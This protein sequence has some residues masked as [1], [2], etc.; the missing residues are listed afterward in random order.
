MQTRDVIV[1]AMKSRIKKA[2]HEYEVE[3]PMPGKD[4]VQHA[5]DLDR[6]NGNTLWRDSLAKEMGNLMIAF[7]ILEPGQKAPPGWFK[8]TG[9]PS[10]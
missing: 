7:K 4:V 9:A 1:S 8:A 6:Q 5:I 3:M 10:S 2:T